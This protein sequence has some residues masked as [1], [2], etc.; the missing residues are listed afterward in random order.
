MKNIQEI[1]IDFT[2]YSINTP[3]FSLN[4]FCTTGRLVDIVDGDSLT[5]ILPLFNNFYKYHVRLC[6]IDTCEMK[7]K[8]K[9]NKDL[10]IKARNTL[11][12]LVVDTPKSPLLKKDIQEILD[13]NIIIVFVECF[14]FDKYGRL[15]ANVYIKK[16]EL[17]INLSEYLLQHKLAYKYTGDTKL[18][19]KEQLEILN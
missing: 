5:I 18:T 17:K 9:E 3:E 7:S 1:E 10:A 12:E 2:N 8:N 13:K 4:G 15:L 19:E 14:D 6:G 16:D 11:L